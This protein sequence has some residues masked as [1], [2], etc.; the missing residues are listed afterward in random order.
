MSILIGHRVKDPVHV[1]SNPSINARD[2]FDPA[3]PGS[4]TDHTV[5]NIFWLIVDET[6]S[7][8]RTAAVPCTR[9]SAI[10]TTR[11]HLFVPNIYVVA[12]VNS[13]ALVVWHD[14]QHRL[15]QG[16][17]SLTVLGG[18][19]SRYSRLEEFNRV[20]SVLSLAESF[21]NTN[22]DVG[23]VYGSSYG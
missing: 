14:R 10:N 8:E 3:I 11:A 7:L 2:A 18:S 22:L 13:G 5:L 9:V 1:I 23:E 21:A 15:E 16:L 12:L 6:R 19:P 17:A 20:I 4:E